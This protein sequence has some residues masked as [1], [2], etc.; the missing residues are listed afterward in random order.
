MDIEQTTKIYWRDREDGVPADVLF[1]L[2]ALARTNCETE[3]YEW[4]IEN[5]ERMYPSLNEFLCNHGIYYCL[6]KL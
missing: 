2:Q 5:D 6:I 4:F 1:D 3:W